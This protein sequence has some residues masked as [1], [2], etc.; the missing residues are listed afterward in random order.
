MKRLAG[1][2]H[3]PYRRAQRGKLCGMAAMAASKAFTAGTT[4]FFVS[5]VYIIIIMGHLNPRRGSLPF[6]PSHRPYLAARD[7]GGFGQ[8]P[9]SPYH[10]PS[11][12][13]TRHKHAAAP[14]FSPASGGSA[15]C[16]C[17]SL[18]AAGHSHA[19]VRMPSEHTVQPSPLP[20]R[21][22]WWRIRP[23]SC[24]RQRPHPKGRATLGLP[25]A[26]L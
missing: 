23:P 20:T 5:K 13:Q 24:L 6:A 1:C 26:R 2:V 15:L 16:W 7:P 17:V 8:K 19:V 9:R 21:P 4:W 18:C 11:Q 14:Q 12:R 22:H 3:G 10:K 25:T